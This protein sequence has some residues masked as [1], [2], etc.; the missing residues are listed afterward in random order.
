MRRLPAL[1]ICVVVVPV[2]TA[3]LMIPDSGAGDRVMLFS[4]VDGSLLDQNWIT[5][6]GAVGWAFTTPKEAAVVGSQI[7][8]SDQVTDA[9]HRFDANRNFL[10]SITTHPGGG[11]L[12]N[13][14]GFG[15]ANNKVYLTVFHGTTSLRGVASYDSSGAPLGFFNVSASFFDAEPIGDD[16]LIT[17]STNNN[18]D[19][20]T[21]TGTP[22]APF[23]TGVVFP[24]QVAILGDGSV[25]AISS[26]ASPGIE[27]I[28]HY[29]ADGSLRRYINTEPAKMQFGEM[30]P[31]GAYVLGNG[32]YLFSTSTG[33]Y[34]YDPD[35]DSFSQILAGV[36]AQYINFIPEPASIGMLGAAL[37]FARRRR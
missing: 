15:V 20:Y 8:V 5:D 18:V 4:D 17:N 9:I 1:A 31:R 6:S 16:L 34:K 27:G 2:A 24:Q 7:W 19:R 21:A 33:V 25:L 32:D 35:S 28:Y 3:D 29:N 30:V 23:A 11:T 37:L 10:G 36:D 14:R 22:L 12:D 26:I 13:V